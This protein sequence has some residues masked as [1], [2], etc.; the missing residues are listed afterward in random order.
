MCNLKY[1]LKH[2]DSLILGNVNIY[3]SRCPLKICK[4]VAAK[5]DG[6][7][8]TLTKTI[9]ELDWGEYSE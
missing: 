8:I 3:L 7:L 5:S 9:P 2:L 4:L 6:Y 1:P